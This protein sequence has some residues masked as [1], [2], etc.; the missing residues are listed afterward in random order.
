M[1]TLVLNEKGEC[2]VAWCTANETCNLDNKT[3]SP[4]AVHY[5]TFLRIDCQEEDQNTV[6]TTYQ[7]LQT[8]LEAGFQTR[9]KH[10][11]G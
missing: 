10:S 5:Y 8:M 1:Y 11:C 4:Y 6:F 7:C 9:L 2:E 3:T